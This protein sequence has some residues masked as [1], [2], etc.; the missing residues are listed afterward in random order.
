MS[1][2]YA[3]ALAMLG[4]LLVAFTPCVY[5]I[6]PITVRYF[7]GASVKSRARVVQ[8]A[9]IY[10][11]GM[12]VL[13]AALG[14]LFASMQHVFGSFMG[15]PV[16]LFAVAA[17]CFCMGAS[18][19][20]LFSLRLPARLSTRLAHAGGSS[21]GGALLMGLVSGL[22]AAPCTGPVLTV[23]LTV[24]AFNAAPFLG[25]LLMTAFALGL[26]LPFMALAISSDALARLPASR[27]MTKMA[28]TVLAVAMF[29]VGGYFAKL[30][31]PA[32][33]VASGAVPRWA[34]L[35]IG[36][37]GLLLFWL[38]RQKKPVRVAAF[39][40][41][42]FGVSTS[43]FGDHG[44]NAHDKI[45]FSAFDQETLTTAARAG[46]PVMVEV[47]AAWCLA[48]KE[49]EDE[50]L[51][52]PA[53]R[54]AARRFVKL[55]IDATHNSDELSEIFQ[56]YGIIGLPTIFF[57]DAAGQTRSEPRV[58]GYVSPARLCAI[59]ERI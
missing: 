40:L 22:I 39:L 50:V 10:V 9:S 4:G 38:G 3:L 24:I 34:A 55:R 33:A 36:C 44:A 56:R 43:L 58:T 21:V 15:S 18:S 13:Y 46:R 6:I 42:V 5:P 28:K 52:H 57:I 11:A 2:P 47:T 16:L 37:L 7:A 26:G 19:L 12:V 20:G 29:V 54:R 49:L 31:W 41:L 23:I 51:S 32:L 53:V 45:V 48:C 17:L 1:L 25:A 27:L 30:A 14:T 35:T 59:L 8:L